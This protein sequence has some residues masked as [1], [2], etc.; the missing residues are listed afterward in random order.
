MSSTRTLASYLS[1]LKYEDLPPEVVE[2]GK[3]AILDPICNSIGGYSLKISRTFLDLAKRTGSGTGEATLIGDGTKISIPMAAFGNGALSTLLDSSDS[4]SNESGLSTTWMGALALPTALA[5]GEY[6]GISGKELITSV[7]AGYECAARIVHSMD[8]TWEQSQRLRG[9]SLGIFAAAGGAARALG[10]DEDQFLSTLGMTGVYT[11][12]PSGHKYLGEDRLT[13]RKDIKQGWAWM[14][15][16]GAFAAVSAELGLKMLQENNILD[17]ER[18][19]WLM[20]GAD[21][22]REEQLTAGLG[23]TFRILGFRTKLYPGIA[24]THSSI[25]G[26]LDLVNENA[27]D[28]GDID[29]VEVLTNKTEGVG[30]GDQDPKGPIEMEFSIPHQIAAALLAGPGGASWYW[31]STAANLQFAEMVKRVSLS[32]DEECEQAYRDSHMRMSKI[33][34]TTKTG[35]RY[36]KIVDR[37]RIIR[38]LDGVRDKFL[39]AAP[40]VIDSERAGKILNTVDN[41]ESLS[42]VSELVDLLAFQPKTVG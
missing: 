12:I 8:K 7:V 15:M 30:F 20:V 23:K 14:C 9:V 42:N 36:A 40:Q 27:I 16:T 22:S 29:S 26:V 6:K 3:A 1:R 24:V 41:L 10:L 37:A 21:V 33:S 4:Q 19:L 39:A 2:K 34:I 25:D 31:E 18:G 38:T 17:G 35:Q 11:P 13:P 32:F 5:A 28:V